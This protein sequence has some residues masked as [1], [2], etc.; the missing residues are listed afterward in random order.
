MAGILRTTNVEG[1]MGIE[2]GRM[3]RDRILRNTNISEQVAEEKPCK[4]AREAGGEP[5]GC[6]FTDAEKSCF[7][8]EIINDL[9]ESI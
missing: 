6:S 4:G 9:G 1:R 7:E 2:K 5:G 3:T 8:K